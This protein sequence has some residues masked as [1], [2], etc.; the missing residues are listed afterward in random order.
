VTV[1]IRCASAM[2][3]TDIRQR[4]E[5]IRKKANDFICYLKA[6]KSGLRLLDSVRRRP[7]I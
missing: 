1:G 2:E 4:E 7:R 3:I 5:A 6:A